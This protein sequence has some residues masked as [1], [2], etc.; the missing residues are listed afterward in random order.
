LENI[1]D[2]EELDDADRLFVHERLA[3]LRATDGSDRKNEERLWVVVAQRGKALV[4]NPVAQKI[5]SEL[6]ETYLKARMGLS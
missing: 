6:V 4:R 3:E 2:Q 5:I 1:L